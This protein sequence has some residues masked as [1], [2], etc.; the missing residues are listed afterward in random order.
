MDEKITKFYEAVSADEE[1][2]AE[3]AEVTEAVSLEEVSEEEAREDM[4]NAIAAFA[5]AHDLDLS[6]QDLLVAD[7]DIVEGRLSEEELQS[8]TGG[9]K[10][11]LCVI[12]GAVTGCGCVIFGGAIKGHALGCTAFGM[13]LA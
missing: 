6:A 9:G 13:H 12:V 3:L 4:A 1:L 8:I 7:A 11:C 10:K 2:Q 5:A